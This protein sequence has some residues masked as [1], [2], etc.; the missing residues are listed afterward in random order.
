MIFL[1]KHF[2][3]GIFKGSRFLFRLFTPSYRVIGKDD[4]QIPVI[5]V[6]SHQNMHGPL[7][8]MAWFE[9][10]VHVLVYNMFCDK[11]DC[12]DQF[13]NYT[14]TQRL[15]WKRLFADLAAKAAAVFVPRL[16]RSMRA[17]P[18]YRG[19]KKVME[20]MVGCHKALL[21]GESLLIFPDID[22]TDNSGMMGDMYRGFLHLERYYFK[23]TG[24]HIP[25]V[26]LCVSK[27]KREIVIGEAVG[28]QN[29]N[30]FNGEK[31]TVYANLRQSI[32]N[33]TTTTVIQ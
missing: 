19:S 5:Y 24:K 33:L 20:T 8:V 1:S 26:P 14:F 25:F 10:P 32:N 3:G 21:R 15:G 4:N 29:E 31:E 13:F 22:Y 7:S 2:Y 27:D 28:F 16:M 23:S 17:I 30:D 11:E 18:V 12:Y 6:A 9:K